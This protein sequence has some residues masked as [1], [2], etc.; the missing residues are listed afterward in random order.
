MRTDTIAFMERY[1]GPPI[2]SAIEPPPTCSIIWAR[3]APSLK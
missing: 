1:G 2:V 3:N